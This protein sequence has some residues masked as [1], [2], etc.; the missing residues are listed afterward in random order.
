MKFSCERA[1]L[2]EAVSIASRAASP[3]NPIPA[4]EGI[5]VEA[6]SSSVRLTGF[7]LKKGAYTSIDA[8]VEEAGSVVIKAR[9]FS[10]IM[11]ALPSDGVVTLEMKDDQSVRIYSGS[12]DFKI[13]GTDY[14]DY[15]ELPTVESQESI[16]LP[17]K[18]L[19]EMIRETIFAVAD[20]ETRPIYTG[21]LFE[22]ENGNLTI[23]AVDGYRLALRREKVEVGEGSYSFIV[24]GGALSD[25]E[26]LCAVGGE[27]VTVTLGAKHISFGIG[28]T[29]IVSRRLE[30]DFLNYRKTVP[31]NFSIEVTAVRSFVQT[32]VERVAL[33]IDDKVK[34]P[35]QCTFGDNVLQMYCATALGK[36]E[37]ACVIDGDGK[38]LVIGFNNSYLLDA[39]KAAPEDEI[40]ICLN[41]GASPC[42]IVPAG[43]VQGEEKFV[44][45]ILPVRLKNN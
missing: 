1:R 23:I 39:L 16:V 32:S 25:V 28:S 37:D 22:I 9:I 41:S 40:K 26:K 13:I 19:G 21:S 17:A 18:I 11:R 6:A 8:A 10:D 7:D 3:R 43:A 45:M 36:A 44:Y 4:L 2:A 29:I 15:P 14:C 5:L 30:G 20:N 38:D 35:I 12:S 31:T 27:T 42:V 24:P 34:N 33:V